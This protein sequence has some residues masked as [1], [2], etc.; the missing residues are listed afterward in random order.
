MNKI[1]LFLITA[2]SLLALVAGAQDLPPT[3]SRVYPGIDNKL[4]YIPDSLGNIIPDFSHAGYKGGGVAIPTVPIKAT[5]WPV[6]G[7]NTEHIQKVID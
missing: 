3:T 1:K 2:F 4:V 6:L 7:D 5:I